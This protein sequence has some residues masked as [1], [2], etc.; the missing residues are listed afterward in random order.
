M[1]T[2]SA[3]QPFHTYPCSA[4]VSGLCLGRLRCGMC[5]MQLLWANGE[6]EDEMHYARA[7]RVR[8]VA[9]IC[10]QTCVRA[11]EGMCNLCLIVYALWLRDAVALRRGVRTY[12]LHY[13]FV[14]S[15]CPW[16]AAERPQLR[17]KW[18]WSPE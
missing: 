10:W 2:A 11:G 16:Q 17:A 14:N 18:G 9:P 4:A 12:A 8:Y 5:D 1:L 13:A 7:R 3:Q 15:V 6:C